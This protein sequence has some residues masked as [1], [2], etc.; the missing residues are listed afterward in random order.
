MRQLQAL[1][2]HH[3]S[4]DKATMLG[5]II[6]YIK[7]MQLQVHVRSCPHYHTA[8]TEDCFLHRRTDGVYELPGDSIGT[9]RLTARVSNPINSHRRS[10]RVI[11]RRGIEDR[12]MFSVHPF[13][14]LT[15]KPQN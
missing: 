1:I 15:A 3:K 12:P 5:E 11:A 9:P 13:S 14:Q 10:Q 6:E 2:P 8:S 7:F 4:N